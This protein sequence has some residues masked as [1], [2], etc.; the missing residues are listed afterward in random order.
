MCATLIR[1]SVY[2]ALI[3]YGRRR[4][5]DYA[6]LLPN[7]GWQQMRSRDAS[8]LRVRYVAAARGHLIAQLSGSAVR[9]PQDVGPA[10]SRG[11]R[12]FT[13]YLEQG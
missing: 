4:R 7:D 1:L 10:A 6:T 2:G 8:R 3:D 11:P 13:H 5:V 12:S 9:N